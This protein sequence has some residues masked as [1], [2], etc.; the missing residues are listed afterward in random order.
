MNRW[1]N[2]SIPYITIVRTLWDFKSFSNKIRRAILLIWVKNIPLDLQ[3]FVAWKQIRSAIIS[4]IFCQIRF[5]HTHRG[6][7]LHAFCCWSRHSHLSCC[8]ILDSSLSSSFIIV[9]SVAVLVVAVVP[10]RVLVV[11]IL[12]IM[13][14]P[15]SASLV[16]PF[17]GFCLIAAICCNNGNCIVCIVI[18]R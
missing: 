9:I 3:E 7:S 10:P 8:W 17:G 13:I 6:Y 2:H 12:F 15:G 11:I 1:N 4:H 16:S 18:Q 5:Y 14:P